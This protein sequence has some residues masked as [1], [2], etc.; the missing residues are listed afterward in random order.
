MDVGSVGKVSFGENDMIAILGLVV[1]LFF[2]WFGWNLF[3]GEDRWRH[4]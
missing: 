1:W 4:V 3:F 2:I